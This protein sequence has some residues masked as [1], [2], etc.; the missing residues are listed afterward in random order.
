MPAEL[1]TA[2]I[3]QPAVQDAP[4]TPTRSR[5]RRVLRHLFPAAL[6][7]ACVA[8]L[9][10]LG[11]ATGWKLP[12][13][14]SPWSEASAGADDWCEEHTVPESICVECRPKLLPHGK[15]YGWC[16]E[17]G[18]PECPLCH[19]EIAHI[20]SLPKVTGADRARAAR[21]LTFAPR[22]ENDEKCKKH[23]RRLQ[24]E[25][26]ELATRLGVRFAPVS[27]GP[28]TE[29]VVAPGE[30]IYDPTRIARATPRAA[31]IVSRVE[32]QIGD[33]VR[34]GEVLALIDSVDV[35]KAKAEFQQS[36]VQLDLR[37]QTLARLR[38]LGG[39]TIPEKDVLAAEAA[40]EEAEVRALTAE[41]TLANLG[42]P[43]RADDA[44]ALS[45]TDLAA[46]MQFLGIPD[47]LARTRRPNRVQQPPPRHRPARRHGG[48]AVGRRGR[49][50][51]PE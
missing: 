7:I 51:Q 9:V 44:Q 12:R 6:V 23:L 1:E 3:E 17:H 22:V 41:Q 19:P 47:P 30:I 29:I 16:A 39:R 18:I 50:R 20:P 40:V 46:R 37:K 10:A 32:R 49:N 27:R 4:A 14:A 15:S 35:G 45:P 25:S 38:P 36:L 28:I 34:K 21:S 11:Q 33:K 8:G 26:D 5:F 31:G 24:L 2:V 43:L 42:I 13:E 48:R